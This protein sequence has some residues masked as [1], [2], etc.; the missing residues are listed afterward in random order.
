M[1]S[2]LMQNEN[3]LL[4]LDNK[5]KIS[6]YNRGRKVNLFISDWQIEKTEM[7]EHLKNLKRSLGCNGSIKLETIDGEEKTVIHLQGDHT[8]NVLNYLKEKG[9]SEDEIIIKE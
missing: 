2:F 6:K 5:I 9:I 1:D 8:Q 3:E 4:S 7:K